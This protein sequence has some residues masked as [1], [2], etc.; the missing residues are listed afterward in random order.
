MHGLLMEDDT[1]LAGRLAD[2]A[3]GIEQQLIELVC[4][5]DIAQQVGKSTATLDAAIRRLHDRLAEVADRV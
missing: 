3:T 4:R 2:V 5:R 1:A